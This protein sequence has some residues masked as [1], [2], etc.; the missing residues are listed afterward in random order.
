MCTKSKKSVMNILNLL[1]GIWKCIGFH[2]GSSPLG[3]GPTGPGSGVSV[4]PPILAI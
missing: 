1:S 4:M 3:S 2:Q